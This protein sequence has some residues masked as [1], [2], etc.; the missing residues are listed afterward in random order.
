MRSAFIPC[1]HISSQDS[2]FPRIIMDKFPTYF[3]AQGSLPVQGIPLVKLFML[4]VLIFCT[5]KKSSFLRLCFV[6]TCLFLAMSLPTLCLR[7]AWW[8]GF[9][10]W[11]DSCMC[12]LSG[13][14]MFLEIFQRIHECN[15]KVKRPLT[16]GTLIWKC[17]SGSVHRA[18]DLD[19]ETWVWF[20]VLPFAS[21]GISEELPN[22]YETYFSWL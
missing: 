15:N 8:V 2:H 11:F 5:W 21:Y 19:R 13:I 4:I 16:L 20:W 7:S 1:D 12:F 6:F 10:L 22:L 9:V 17:L 18:L 14:R 3:E